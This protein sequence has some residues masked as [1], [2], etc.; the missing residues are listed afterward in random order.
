MLDKTQYF[1]HLLSSSKNSSYILSFK[2]W[3]TPRGLNILMDP[4]Y[5]LYNINYY[6]C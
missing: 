1:N 3:G 6:N 5:T 2:E 4:P